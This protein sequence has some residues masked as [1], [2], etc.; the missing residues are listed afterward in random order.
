[1]V[2]TALDTAVVAEDSASQDDYGVID[3]ELDPATAAQLAG[4]ED[5]QGW[6]DW[7]VYQR[8]QPTSRFRRIQ[9]DPW[10]DSALWPLVF[11]A[12]I[13]TRLTIH[14]SLPGT[15]GIEEDYFLEGVEESVVMEGDPRPVIFWNVSRAEPD[16]FWIVETRSVLDTDTKLAY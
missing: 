7:L 14:H 15:T 10:A 11:A 8:S 4:A 13:G 16:S 9:I 2:Q 3:F 12:D 5:A 1:M 6:A